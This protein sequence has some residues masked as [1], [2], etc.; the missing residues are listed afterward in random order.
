MCYVYNT[1]RVLNLIQ[2]RLLDFVLSEGGGR[3]IVGST[4]EGIEGTERNKPCF[5]GN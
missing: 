3:T 4:F 1:S 5:K 2:L